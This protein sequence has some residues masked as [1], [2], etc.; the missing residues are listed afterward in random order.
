HAE[1]VV[2]VLA[3]LLDEAVRARVL[4]PLVAED[5]VVR[6]VADLARGVAVV[7]QLEA[8]AAPVVLLGADDA[9][10]VD[11]LAVD[12]LVEDGRLRAA[13]RVLGRSVGRSGS[14]R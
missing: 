4:L 10:V 12:E 8:V 5:A 13:R 9:D 11:F 7:S 2:L 14:D 6:L 1:R 3:V